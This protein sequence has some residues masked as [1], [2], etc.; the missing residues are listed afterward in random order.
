MDNETEK[1]VSEDVWDNSC[2]MNLSVVDDS[3]LL[4]GRYDNGDVRDISVRVMRM[5][6]MREVALHFML[7]LNEDFADDLLQDAIDILPYH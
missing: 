7:H 2:Y 5:S 6:E 4:M 1:I 3:T